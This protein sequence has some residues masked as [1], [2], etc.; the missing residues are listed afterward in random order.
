MCLSSAW[1]RSIMAT[2]DGLAAQILILTLSAAIV[3]ERLENLNKN[4]RKPN[5]AQL[6]HEL[7]KNG[8]WGWGVGGYKAGS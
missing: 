7:E 5:D 2:A 1:T 3:S 8:Y 6:E 4:L